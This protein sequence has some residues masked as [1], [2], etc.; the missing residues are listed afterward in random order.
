MKFREIIL[1]TELAETIK[2][3]I[4]V[5]TL[6]GKNVLEMCAF[7]SYVGIWFYQGSFLNDP[8]KKLVNA[9]E[10]KTKA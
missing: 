10:G 6:G 5:Y 2:W 3:G 8:N 1:A 7:Q 9:R 4:P